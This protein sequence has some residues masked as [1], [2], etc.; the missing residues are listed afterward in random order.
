MNTQPARQ[1]VLR[2]LGV[3]AVALALANVAVHSRK[4]VRTSASTPAQAAEPLVKNVEVAAP[5]AV[6][7]PA[8]N[9]PAAL[10]SW[11][12][13]ESADYKTYIAN[14]RKL[15]FPEELIRE[16]VVADIDK[17]YGP[18]EEPLKWKPA[19]HDASLAQRRKQP[20]V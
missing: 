12:P 7:Q 19:P 2:L 11:Q 16:I 4:K 14:L 6:Q 1:S 13:V 8:T 10:F 17:F 20:T 18:R 5:P 15:S 3:L 9:A